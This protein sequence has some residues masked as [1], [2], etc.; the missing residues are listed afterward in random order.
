MSVAPIIPRKTRLKKSLVNYS[1][2][3]FSQYDYKLIF[4][5]NERLNHFLNI[6]DGLFIYLTLYTVKIVK[7]KNN[8]S[9]VKVKSRLMAG[10]IDG[11]GKVFSL[12]SSVGF[13]EDPIS[14][15]LCVKIHVF[16]QF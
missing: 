13:D 14:H 8:Y 10:K 2:N 7:T 11:L 6:N 5:A 16:H 9:P 1:K 12:D 3:R 15:I 4:K